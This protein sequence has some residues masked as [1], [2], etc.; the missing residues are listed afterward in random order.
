[1]NTVA[2]DAGSITL[3]TRHFSKF[4][5]SAIDLNL[6]DQDIDSGYQPGVD[7]WQ[8]VNNGSFIEK[9]GHCAGQSVSS[10]GITSLG[11]TV[12]MYISTDL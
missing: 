10:S 4:F 5:I 8:F 7:D 12:R 1:M 2:Q 3:A 11:R 6:L 9:G